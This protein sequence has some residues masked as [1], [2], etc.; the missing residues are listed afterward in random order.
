MIVAKL[1]RFPWLILTILVVVTFGGDARPGL[2][3]N[4]A[5]IVVEPGYLAAD[6]SW[7][8]VVTVADEASAASL[9]A[10]D[11]AVLW[12][13]QQLEIKERL[14]FP[15]QG[16]SPTT[17]LAIVLDVPPLTANVV[18]VWSAALA[19]LLN[20]TATPGA[21]V[22]VARCGPD[23][24]APPR[25]GSQ[26]LTADQWGEMLAAAQPG[27]LWDSVLEG[28]KAVAE[29]D[30]P[31][32]RVLLLVSDG[33]E[34]LVSRHVLASCIEAALRARV[35]IYVLS[36]AAGDE[37]DAGAARLREL[38]RRTGGQELSGG[39]R[40]A[41][42]LADIL[43][44]IGSAQGLRLAAETEELPVEVS[45]RWNRDAETLAAGEIARRESLRQPGVGRWLILGVA[46][47]VAG[48]AGY[49]IWRQRAIVVGDLLV[50][51]KNGVRRF[52]VPQHGV[53][54]G[55]AADNSLVL[56]RPLVSQHHAV[57]RAKDGEVIITD[58]RSSRGTTVNDEP[59]GTR[60]LVS[61]DR[62]VV[63]GAVEMVFKD[64]RS[65]D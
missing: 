25:P 35:A 51:T 3:Q 18:E 6:G 41:P 20:R 11:L 59:I 22:S 36:L 40:L 7:V 39:R 61:G 33:R 21:L 15:L 65:R 64:H 54:I 32:R 43:A 8:V 50:R 31:G 17:A 14:E 9:A 1:M 52:P 27:K 63:G 58:L 30:L 62:I 55:R 34:E 29:R 57:I 16:D 60:H 5:P 23:A 56:S 4:S 24:T 13:G 37:S 2:G 48:G 19:N 49:L 44:V 53:T 12:E 45:V 26:S 47:L 38:A 46:L 28:V 42:R 10:T